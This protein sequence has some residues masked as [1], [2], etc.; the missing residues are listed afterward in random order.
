MRMCL[1]FTTLV[2]VHISK[3]LSSV[4]FE[5][6]VSLNLN[7]SVIKSKCKIQTRLLKQPYHFTLF[8]FCLWCLSS[9]VVTLVSL[10]PSTLHCKCSTVLLSKFTMPKNIYI[11]GGEYVT[12][13]FNGLFPPSGTIQYS[14][15][16]YAIMS[17]SIVRSCEWYQNSEA[18][19]TTFMGPIHWGT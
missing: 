12:Q 10:H 9:S 13:T 7:Y 17:F 3:R 15:V 14:T 11:Y 19:H 8:F 1:C 5:N 16:R 2:F 6:K 4:A 18:Y